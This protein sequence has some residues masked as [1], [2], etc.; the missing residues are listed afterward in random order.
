MIFGI[1]YDGTFSKDPD[2]FHDLITLMDE[3]RHQAI[4]VT[5]RSSEQD[6]KEVEK[7]VNGKIPIIF[8]GEKWKSETVKE[9]GYKI[10]IWIDDMP[11][12]IFEPIPLIG[13][14]IN[15]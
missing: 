1:D 14:K 3:Y 10:D 4:I 11:Q 5:Q 12:G 13:K 9:E 7:Q 6:R 15:E 8:A 2:F